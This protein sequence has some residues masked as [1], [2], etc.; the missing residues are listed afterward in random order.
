M[1]CAT[2]TVSEG[3]VAA[4]L[5]RCPVMRRAPSKWKRNSMRRRPRRQERLDHARPF[6]RAHIEQEEA[7]SARAHQLPSDGA[8]TTCCFIVLV[9]V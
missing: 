4:K 7:S 5:M 8:R 1:A 6:R 2:R 3:S 9:D